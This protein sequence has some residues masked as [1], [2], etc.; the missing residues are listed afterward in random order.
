MEEKVKKAQKIKG[1]KTPRGVK[2]NRA[3]LKFPTPSPI[4]FP[5]VDT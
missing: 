4:T 3:R 5:M 1:E 2:N